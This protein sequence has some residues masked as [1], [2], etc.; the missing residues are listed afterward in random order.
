MYKIQK[1]LLWTW[2]FILL[3][4]RSTSLHCR[5][6]HR[7]SSNLKAELRNQPVCSYSLVVSTQNW[8]H[9]WVYTKFSV[10]EWCIKIS[11]HAKLPL[12]ITWWNHIYRFSSIFRFLSLS[13][14]MHKLTHLVPS[15]SSPVGNAPLLSSCF[16][17][18]T[19]LVSSVHSVASESTT[20]MSNHW[21]SCFS[22][23]FSLRLWTNLS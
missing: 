5:W 2:V 3:Q 6:G 14:S 7:R 13:E 11:L 1:L 20:I 4:P 19:Y 22:G 21:G 23:I 18:H 17:F 12:D 16:Q 15:M 9:S 10:L 8:F